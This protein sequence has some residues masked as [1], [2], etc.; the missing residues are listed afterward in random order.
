VEKPARGR[1][2]GAGCSSKDS[3]AHLI[4]QRGEASSPITPDTEKQ[5][6]RAME[7]HRARANTNLSDVISDPASDPKLIAGRKTEQ[8]IS[9]NGSSSIRNPWAD[10]IN[11]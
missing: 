5:L 4:L 11:G 9:P 1:Q 6:E 8:E 7:L 2:R 3:E 10:A